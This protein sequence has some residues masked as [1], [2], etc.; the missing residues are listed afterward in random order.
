MGSAWRE[1]A[2]DSSTWGTGT[3]PLGFGNIIGNELGGP[4][5]NPD[6]HL[7]VYFRRELEVAVPQLI[8]EATVEVMSD[9]GAI[10]SLNGTEIARDNMPE[11]DV[12]F[13]TPA[14]SDSNGSEGTF[15]SFTFAPSAFVAGTNLIAV[16][17]HNRSVGS[18]D[19]GMDL[20][21]DIVSTNPDNTPT[22]RNLLL[23]GGPRRRLWTGAEGAKG[24]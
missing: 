3:A 7:T 23:A 10:V 8:T 21:I 20:K 4:E 9:G 6:S 18:S 19:M 16:E 13:D 12:S 1:A 24:G 22:A 2:F 17:L 5:I 11:G 14:L 15:D